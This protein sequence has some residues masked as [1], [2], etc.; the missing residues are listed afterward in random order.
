MSADITKLAKALAAGVVGFAL[1]SVL[2]MLVTWFF[3]YAFFRG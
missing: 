2:V 3:V 1:S